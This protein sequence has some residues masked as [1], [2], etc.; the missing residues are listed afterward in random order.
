ML[1]KNHNSQCKGEQHVDV[2]DH[3]GRSTAV[4]VNGFCFTKNEE[5]GNFNSG[6]LAE[7]LKR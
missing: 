4:L 2:A 1:E 7:S 6:P 3:R 5:Q